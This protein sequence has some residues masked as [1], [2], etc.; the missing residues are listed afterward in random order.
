M[1][2]KSKIDT[3]FDRFSELLQFF[4]KGNTRKRIEGASY[5]FTVFSFLL[6]LYNDFIIFQEKAVIQKSLDAIPYMTLWT[7]VT[8]FILIGSIVVVRLIFTRVVK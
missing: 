7:V 1:T 2:D 5:A 8:V 3:I 6:L 4:S